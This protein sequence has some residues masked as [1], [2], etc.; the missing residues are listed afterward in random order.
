MKG[1]LAAL[2]DLDDPAFVYEGFEQLRHARV[3]RS[4]RPI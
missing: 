2:F 4:S 1:L 3:G